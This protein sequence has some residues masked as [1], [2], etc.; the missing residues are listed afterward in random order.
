MN[1][2]RALIRIFSLGRIVALTLIGL[3]VLGLDTGLVRIGFA[4]SLVS[5]ARLLAA[6][7]RAL[8]DALSRDGSLPGKPLSR[9]TVY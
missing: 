8:P 3:T 5:Q 7:A 4:V 6:P 9:H 2:E 1:E